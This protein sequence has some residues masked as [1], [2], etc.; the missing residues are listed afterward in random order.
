MRSVFLTPPTLRLPPRTPSYAAPHPPPTSLGTLTPY[1]G[2]ASAAPRDS[3]RTDAGTAPAQNP[4][5]QPTPRHSQAASVET[6][7]PPGT[8]IAAHSS[9]SQ[10]SRSSS[11]PPH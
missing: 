4:L 5:P 9:P 1:C 7:T 6:Y 2:T 11:L 10:P 3:T 8:P